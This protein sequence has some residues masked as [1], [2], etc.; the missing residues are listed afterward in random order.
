LSTTTAVR[1]RRLISC[2]DEDEE[3]VDEMKK[4]FEETTKT[5]SADL[6]STKP[7]EPGELI[8]KQ[9]KTTIQKNKIEVNKKSLLVA[10][11]EDELMIMKQQTKIH[12]VI[13][14]DRRCEELAMVVDSRDPKPSSTSSS[15]VIAE[16]V[17][18]SSN[19]KTSAGTVNNIII[20]EKKK[21]KEKIGEKVA[22]LLRKLQSDIDF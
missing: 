22:R 13:S 19:N 12:A 16:I 15:S 2:S 20:D 1:K 6:I 9:Q 10:E 21:K 8:V 14:D 4:S 3:N 17:S 18:S 7:N 11:K 5:K